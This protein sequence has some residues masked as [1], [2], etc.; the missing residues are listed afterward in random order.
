MRFQT[1]GWRTIVF[2]NRG[3]LLVPV[4]IVLL[5]FGR[6]SPASA[7]IGIAIAALGE[8]IRIWAVGYSG[9]TTRADIVTAPQ[10][11]TAGPYGVVRNPLY[12]ANGIIAF[13]F[14]FAFA[15]GV[16]TIE[17]GAMLAVVA[18]LVIGVYAIIIPLEESYLAGH[19]GE[20]YARY[21]GSVPRVLPAGSRLA[22]SERVGVWRAA[23]IGRAE[24][25]T[26][27]FFV[28]M[29]AAVVLKIGP[30][31]GWGVYF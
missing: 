31:S 14:W 19:F 22:P 11:V 9:A 17:A 13:G 7:L 15:G 28:L 10:L 21:V 23:V 6:P 1:G 25:I 5:V 26:L 29:V 20:A 8:A 12:L 4:A 30:L 24:I 27:A 16:S 3:A 2:K 18:V